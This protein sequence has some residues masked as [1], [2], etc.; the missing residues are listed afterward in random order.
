MLISCYFVSLFP[1]NIPLLLPRCLAPKTFFF[2]CLTVRRLIGGCFKRCWDIVAEFLPVCRCLRRSCGGGDR[3][4]LRGL[5]LSRARR[6]LSLTML[7]KGYGRRE[8]YRV[9]QHPSDFVTQLWDE[10]Q[11]LPPAPPPH[12][13]WMCEMS[14]RRSFSMVRL[15]CTKWSLAAVEFWKAT[16]AFLTPW[17]QQCDKLDPTPGD[18]FCVDQTLLQ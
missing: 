14:L 12:G 4:C 7:V 16:A 13:T 2:F 9:V 18:Y 1:G 8:H 11:K 6:A 5:R 17:W 15:F 10:K 3:V